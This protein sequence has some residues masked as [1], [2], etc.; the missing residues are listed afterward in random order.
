MCLAGCLRNR[1]GI[2]RTKSVCYFFIELRYP[3]LIRYRWSTAALSPLLVLVPCV[4]DISHEVQVDGIK[5]KGIFPLV[6]LC[7]FLRTKGMKSL[8]IGILTFF[9]CFS[10]IYKHSHHPIGHSS[11]QLQIIRFV[12]P[13]I[14]SSSKAS[15]LF[16]I[17]F[18]KQESSYDYYSYSWGVET[19]KMR[20]KF[21][22]QHTFES[23]HILA[24]QVVQQ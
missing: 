17:A 1:K 23:V 6:F 22:H 13:V 11:L 9:M 20:N 14:W 19:A 15:K 7:Q 24:I 21:L 18:I 2:I 5:G 12:S 8:E 16:S 10:Y 3:V 4:Q